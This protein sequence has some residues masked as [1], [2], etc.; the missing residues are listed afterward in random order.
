MGYIDVYV[1]PSILLHVYTYAQ[2]YYLTLRILALSLPR[3]SRDNKPLT[4]QHVPLVTQWVSLVMISLSN[5]SSQTSVR[6]HLRE[7]GHGT[8]KKT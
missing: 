2:S 8:T 7:R 6:V 3:Y 5:C 4:I 1:C